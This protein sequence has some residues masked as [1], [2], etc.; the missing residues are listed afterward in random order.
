MAQAF[1]W[2]AILIVVLDTSGGP[3][4]A[5]LLGNN[6]EISGPGCRFPDVA[7]G[8]VSKKYLVVWADY[9]V[10]RIFGRLV[11]D[12]GTPVGD[13]FQISEAPS[14]GLFPA[15]AYNAINDEFLVTWDDFGRRGD[16]IHGQ[17]VRAADGALLG[18]NLPIGSVA[19]GIR[20][21]VA[22]SPTNNIYLVVYWGG[23]PI[24]EVLGQR[25][26]ASGGLLGGNFNIS[27][28]GVFSGYPAVAWGASS[29]QFLVSWDNE[30]G[31][32]H[33]RR[34]DSATGALLGSTIFVTTGGAK[35]RSCIAYD[36][37]VNRW[38]VQFNDGANAGFSY[39]QSGQ[40][41]N[42]NG[43]LLGGLISLAHTASFEGDTQF[44]GDV[45]FVPIARRYFSSFG[46][47]TG[48]GGQESFASGN[49][50]RPQV[51]LGAGYYTSLNNAADP[52]RNLV[53]TAW[54][55]LVGGSF[56]IYGQLFATTIN[57]V[58]IFAAAGQNAQVALSWRTPSDIH[59]TGTMLRFRTD[60]YPAGPED[61][62]LVTDKLSAPN[63]S[64]A[65]TH[66]NLTNWTTYYYSAFAHDV[67]SN[68][69]L[70]AQAAATPRPAVVTI[71]SSEFTLDVDGWTLATWQSG[72]LAPGTIA[73]EAS[74]FSILSTGSGQSNN[75]DACTREGGLI[76]R[77]ISTAGHQSIQVEYDVMAALNAPPAGSSTGGCPV[78][79]SSLEDKL[80][81]YYSTAGTNGPWTV[82][83]TLSEGVELPTAWIRKL[84]NLA[85]VSAVN[86]NPNFALRFQW[87]F[88]SAGDT[89]RVDNIRVLSSA[90]TA[91]TPIIALST[92][93]IE[94]T[95]QRG[96]SPPPD[97]LRINNPGEGI[98][99]FTVS[100]D[101]PW[102]TV[103]PISG[104]SP[105]PDLTI[106]LGYNTAGLSPADYEATIQVTAA[107]TNSPQTT[108][109]LLHVVP[110]ACFREP[111]DYYDGYLTTMGGANWSGSAT[112]QL[113]TETGTVRIW[114]GGGTVSATHVVN[115][116]G[117][118]GI[119]AAQIKISKGSGSGDFFWNIAID[120]PAGN[121]FARWYGGSTIARGRVGNNITADMNL[122]GTTIWNDLFVKI[123]TVANSSEF[124]FN[125]ESFGAIPH[126]ATASNVVGSIRLE[127]LDRASAI[128][129]FIHFDNL[130]LG[131]PDTRPPKLT[132]HR[133]GTQL[134]LSWP[135]E[136]AEFQLQSTP[137]LSPL[138]QWSPVPGP[139]I[140]T[141]GK[142]T[143]A[144]TITLS[145]W[146]YRLRAR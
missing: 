30:D 55:G 109:V 85:G 52:L 29:N 123:D 51:A 61:G 76:T 122:V 58:L 36:S 59:F 28:D 137:V 6:F 91:P 98:L 46:T 114:G 138:P 62:A 38:L 134:L 20:S 93:F 67:G 72:A 10:T 23:H 71:D 12:E 92:T 135:A 120:D 87:Q 110:S 102:L 3:L 105:G 82:A 16:V 48:M 77:V 35:D 2:W 99:N 103:S 84:I 57:P 116:A 19:G 39:D 66:T 111:F 47:D 21:A 31:N 117:S 26:S 112:H 95:A 4:H 43:T 8:T 121:N 65:F 75:R 69:S 40:L 68:Y 108:R 27:N 1:T 74:T 97:F 146:F 13:A 79:E 125:G 88:N 106:T 80:V 33:A 11:T 49:P 142:R 127:R 129:D 96:Q 133:A 50:V 104:S 128:N 54:E 53:L 100:D 5:A 34:V 14:G 15:A 113:R 37:V 41:I 18:T 9:N 44:G 136:G 139:S 140:L 118:N 119:I 126:E 124:F 56:R 63:A 7:Y 45:A 107:T 78:L 81:V 22:W 64:D 115:C 131:A 141:E 145:N 32:I 144:T 83:Q 143:F 17:R 24:I 60:G 70:V 86:D 94:R 101:A 89:G 25:V 73:R 42:P 132:F 90:V 130:V